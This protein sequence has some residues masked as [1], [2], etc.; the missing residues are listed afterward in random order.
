MD[1]LTSSLQALSTGDANGE[2]A[3][4][5][6]ELDSALDPSTTPQ[7][8]LEK[9][10]VELQVLVMSKAPTLQSLSALVHAS[11][12]LHRIYIE[13]RVPILRSVLAQILN[14]ML[15]DALGVYHSSTNL[16]QATR[17]ESLLWAF[18]HEHEAKYTKTATDWTAELSFDDII[19]LLRFHTSVLEPLTERYASW[20]LA[21]LPCSSTEERAGQ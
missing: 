9:L 1:K 4:P 18:V 8:S 5:A 10:P 13:D 3:E 16:F 15:V 11:P 12:Q 7:P 20:A 6:K 19:H 17:E 21:S 2:G 14:G